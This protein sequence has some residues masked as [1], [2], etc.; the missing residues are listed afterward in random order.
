MSFMRVL[1]QGGSL[2]IKER[3]KYDDLVTFLDKTHEGT[4][5]TCQLSANIIL[6][7]LE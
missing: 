6:P 2:L 5:H 1:P 7:T 3:L 4:Q